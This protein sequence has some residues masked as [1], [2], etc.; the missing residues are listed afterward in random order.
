MNQVFNYYQAN[1][2]SSAPIGT[3]SLGYML[4]AIQSPKKNVKQTFEAIKRAEEEGDMNFKMVLKSRLYS[5]TPCVLVSQRRDY[6]HIEH[7]TGLMQID[8]DHLEVKIA[9]EFKQYLFET[10]KYI[11]AS[12]LS[13]SGHGVKAIV[14][15][16]VS[17]TVEEFKSYFAAIEQHLGI[18]HGFDPAPKNC[19]LPMFIS[20]DPDII[21]RNN[22]SVFKHRYHKMVSTPVRQYIVNDQTHTVERIIALKIGRIVDNG[23]PQLRAASY[24]MGGYVGAG[25]ID[26]EDAKAILENMIETNG[27]LKLKADIYKKTANQMIE[28]GT[29]EPIYLKE[30]V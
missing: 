4:N 23:H 22:P 28:K 14:N 13:P 30:Y 15:I 21:I 7:F 26:M 19:V 6:S 1:I 3:V 2:K 11:Y 9:V 27:Y 10:Y 25:Y 20:Y 5:F 8:F 16:P 29:N 18:Y 12:W 24:L 17:K